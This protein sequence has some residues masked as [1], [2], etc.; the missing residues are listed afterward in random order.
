MV[1][2]NAGI[3]VK[4]DGNRKSPGKSAGKHGEKHTVFCIMEFKIQIKRIAQ[5]GKKTEFHVLPGGF[6]YREEKSGCRAVSGPLIDKVGKG[7]GSQDKEYAFEQ[8]AL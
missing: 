2:E 5:H 1:S 7:T 4:Y 8:V 6:V 3:C